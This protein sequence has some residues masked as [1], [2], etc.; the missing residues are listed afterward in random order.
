MKP[1]EL[2][3]CEAGAI[4]MRCSVGLLPLFL[5]GVLDEVRAR[6][7]QSHLDDCAACRALMELERSPL[8]A[9]PGLKPSVL[10]RM[11]RQLDALENPVRLRAACRVPA[12]SPRCQSSQ[13]GVAWLSG[14]CVG[15][16]FTWGA[17]RVSDSA[18]SMPVERQ[19]LGEAEVEAVA[20]PEAVFSGASLVAAA[21][22]FSLSRKALGGVERPLWGGQG[23]E[24]SSSS[25]EDLRHL[26]EMS[27]DLFPP[28]IPHCPLHR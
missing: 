2:D 26:S 22:F 10:G 5:D 14:V 25:Y 3:G 18:A 8:E 9:L 28:S 7:V 12:S 23:W 27:A 15:V 6:Q 24:L 13:W 1:S 11:G 20:V 4:S 17:A 19:V 16:L 21:P